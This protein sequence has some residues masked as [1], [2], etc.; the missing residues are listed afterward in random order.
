MNNSFNTVAKAL[1]YTLL[2]L[3][4]LLFLSPQLLGV[5]LCG[6]LTLTLVAGSLRRT[7]AKLNTQYLEEKS[8]LVQVSEETFSNI[9]TVKAFCNAKAEIKKFDEINNR[10]IQIG[11]RRA[12]MSGLNQTFAY[13]L[14]YFTLA[15]VTYFGVVWSMEKSHANF[16]KIGDKK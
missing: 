9:R 8:K 15:A 5:L 3:M 2:V 10:V 4:Y 16:L 13:M 7:T 14:L 6:L 11:H 1:V 12:V